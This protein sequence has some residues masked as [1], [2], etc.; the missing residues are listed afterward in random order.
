MAAKQQQCDHK[1]CSQRST[2][3]PPGTAVNSLAEWWSCP[4]DDDDLNEDIWFS[5][6]FL[7]CEILSKT[8]CLQCASLCGL[9]LS[10]SINLPGDDAHDLDSVCCCCC[11]TSWPGR[12]L[13]GA[14]QWATPVCE[15]HLDK[16]R[17]GRRLSMDNAMFRKEV[18]RR[19]TLCRRCTRYDITQL[20]LTTVL[21]CIPCSVRH[22]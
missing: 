15:P 18:K 17:C 7:I 4:I 8:L 12:L 20:P 2:N 5:I 16:V 9:S 14:T 21:Q 22:K 19:C 11:F 3:Q 13:C 6:A 10:L 1:T